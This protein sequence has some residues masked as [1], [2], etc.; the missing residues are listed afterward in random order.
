MKVEAPLNPAMVQAFGPGLEKGVKS[1]TPTHFN[2]DCREAGPG[3]LHVTMLN[4]EGR[5]VLFSITDNEDGIYT[6]DYVAPQ[7][8]NYLVH[9][10][11]GGLKVPHGPYKITVEPHVD[12]SKIKVD[13]LARSKYK[14]VS[15]YS[16]TIIRRSIII[17]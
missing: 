4:P 6:V 17:L 16:F 7:P 3:D 13:G 14:I 9:L 10:N 5:E 11:Y 1:N 12:V 15:V 2:I 8:G